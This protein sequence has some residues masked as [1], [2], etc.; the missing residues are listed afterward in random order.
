MDRLSKD[1]LDYIKVENAIKSI[2]DPKELQ[3][4]IKG[5]RREHVLDIAAFRLN[6]L[7]PKQGEQPGPI[8]TMTHEF[9]GSGVEGTKAVIPDIPQSAIRNPKSHIT[10]NDI[11]KEIDLADEKKA[12]DF[13]RQATEEKAVI[14]KAKQDAAVP[15]NYVT[16][17]DVIKKMRAEGKQI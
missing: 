1:I 12:L 13:E 15:R 14:D 4:F 6:A 10:G 11:V 16:G 9:K 8:T 3:A 2:M 5:E 17:E 7:K